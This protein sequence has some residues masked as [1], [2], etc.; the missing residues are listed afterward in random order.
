M[1]LYIYNLIFIVI[2][3]IGPNATTSVALSNKPAESIVLNMPLPS[4]NTAYYANYESINYNSSLPLT[5]VDK[6]VA[7]VNKGVITTVEVNDQIAQTI[8]TYK[9]KGL[10]PPSSDDIRRRVIDE[11]IMQKIELDFAARTGIKTTD[12][13]VASAINNIAGQNNMNLEQFKQYI[14]KQGLTFDKFKQQIN[15]QITID[16]LKQREVDGRVS[17]NVHEVDLVLNSEA[18]KNRMDYNLSDIII[19]VPDKASPDVIVQKQNLAIAAYNELKN[20]N[21]FYKVSA[22]YSNS[23][24]ALTGGVLG[25]KSNAVLPPDIIKSLD[26]VGVGG[27][28]SII[29]LSVG[30]FIFKVNDIKKHGAPQMVHQ[31]HVRH[32]LIKVND[33]TSDNEAHQKIIGIRNKILENAKNPQIESYNFAGLAKKYSEDTSSIKGGDLGWVSRGDTVPVF[34]SAVINTPIGVISQPIHSGF[35][36]HILEV[37]GTRDV[38]LSDDREKAEIRQEIHDSKANTLYIEWQRNIRDAAYV[39]MNDE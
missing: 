17:V 4:A 28:T 10:T 21:P 6:I 18:Y 9:Q 30:F 20:G 8:Q 33:A 26:G 32:I 11:L 31:Y 39:K 36:W 13:E 14:M 22:K 23:P 16:K 5:T 3:M 37:L 19:G 27:I 7:Y 34:E 12:A 35:G 25:W 2:I 1:Y 38:N 15:D 29:H 24:N